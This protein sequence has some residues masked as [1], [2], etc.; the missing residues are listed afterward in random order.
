MNKVPYNNKMNLLKTYKE[1]LVYT[2]QLLFKA[3]AIY[4]TYKKMVKNQNSSYS[5]VNTAQT[6]L[7]LINQSSNYS[8]LNKNQLK[9][10]P[11]SRP[12]K[13]IKKNFIP[14]TKP[15]LSYK[16]FIKPKIVPFDSNE[17]RFNW[18]NINKRFY[19]T[20]VNNLNKIVKDYYHAK[21]FYFQEGFKGFYSTHNKI[22]DMPIQKRQKKKLNLL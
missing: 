1:K 18:Q 20:G 17:P 11:I 6:S 5:N 12:K 3:P 14:K 2:S 22:Y 13:E 19:P 15:K 21:C 4:H 7:A 10:K 8:T 9:H 16:Q